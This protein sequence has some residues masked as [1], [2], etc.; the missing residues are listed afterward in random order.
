VSGNDIRPAKRPDT[1]QQFEHEE[2]REHQADDPQ[3]VLSRRS[4]LGGEATFARHELE[5]QVGEDGADVQGDEGEHAV[6]PDFGRQEAF[7]LAASRGYGGG[8]RVWS[9]IW[10]EQRTVLIGWHVVRSHGRERC[11]CYYATRRGK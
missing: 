11:N 1:S 9:V 2:T 4:I 8:P 5:D 10:R 3:H 7:R 6:V